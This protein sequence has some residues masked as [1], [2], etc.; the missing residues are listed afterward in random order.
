[1]TPRGYN[2][3]TGAIIEAE[4]MQWRS[5]YRSLAPERQMLAA[6]IVWL[7]QHGADSTWLRR[8]PCT[9]SA[10]EALDYLRDADCLAQWQRLVATCPGW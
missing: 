3:E 9:W 4:M 5:D 1:M 7:Y 10:I 8:V 2:R 6:T